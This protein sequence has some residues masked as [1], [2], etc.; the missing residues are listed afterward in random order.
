MLEALK[1]KENKSKPTEKGK[2]SS[3]WE[4]FVLI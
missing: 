2:R 3:T 4:S 1:Q